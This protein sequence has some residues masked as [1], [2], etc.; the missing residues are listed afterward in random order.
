MSDDYSH[1][2]VFLDMMQELDAF[3]ED[4]VNRHQL[5]GLERDDPDLRRL[6]EAMGF[7]AA[8][9]QFAGQNYLANMRR[10][11]LKEFFPYLL[12][13][14]PALVM[15]QAQPTARLS[16]VVEMPAGTVLTGTT[17]QN[18]RTGLIRTLADMRIVPL[19]LGRVQMAALDETRMRIKPDSKDRFAVMMS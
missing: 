18:Q 11:L 1:R 4:Y 13:P 7:F 14:V 15:L 3:R 10:S 19:E 5:S 2:R 12:S 16:E 6:T 8:R 17:A 9:A